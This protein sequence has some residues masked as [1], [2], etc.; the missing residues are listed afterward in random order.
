MLIANVSSAV[1]IR[2]GQLIKAFAAPAL[3]TTGGLRAARAKPPTTGGNTSCA[4]PHTTTNRRAS[5]AACRVLC[6]SFSDL[7]FASIAGVAVTREED[8]DE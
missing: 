5:F 4:V 1:T 8:E 3:T 6:L 2:F 7:A